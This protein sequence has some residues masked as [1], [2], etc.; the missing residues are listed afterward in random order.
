MKEVEVEYRIK[1]RMDLPERIGQNYWT[2]KINDRH[3][4]KTETLVS[5]EIRVN[6]EKVFEIE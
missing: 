1:V 5:A 6:G 2:E 4:P 3:Y